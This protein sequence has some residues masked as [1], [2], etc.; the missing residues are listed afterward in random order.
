MK[1]R[2][3][4]LLG[5]EYPIIQ[6]GMNYAAYPPLVAAVSNA[7]GLGILG[8]GSTWFTGGSAGGFFGLAKESNMILT[9]S[10]SWVLI[11]F[12][13][14]SLMMAIIPNDFK[15]AVKEILSVIV[16]LIVLSGF[17]FLAYAMY[18]TM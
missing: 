15:L 9:Q 3:T 12:V 13:I 8:A 6:A 1:T 17:G 18:I 4:E 14:S 2:I 7:G 11:L 16:I 10:C 5:T